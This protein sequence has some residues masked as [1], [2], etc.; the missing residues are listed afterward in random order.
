MSSIW[1]GIQWLGVTI[2]V[3]FFMFSA[4]AEFKLGYVDVDKALLATKEGKKVD[5][6]LKKSA[7]KKQK[8]LARKEAEIK[9][10]M[11]DLDKKRHIL[12]EDDFKRKREAIQ[13]E[14]VNL[15][16]FVGKSRVEFENQRSR[17]LK[18]LAEKME[19]VIA[20]VARREGYTMILRRTSQVVLWADGKGDLTNRIVRAFEKKKKEEGIKKGGKDGKEPAG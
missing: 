12:E 5:V 11:G 9:K 3:S 13:K 8:E 16:E 20:E 14:M 6:T 19:R 1:R 18:P 7:E 2:G 15:Q 4:Q 10:M 17:L